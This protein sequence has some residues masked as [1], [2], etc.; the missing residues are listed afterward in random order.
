[1]KRLAFVAVAVLAAVTAAPSFAAT[2]WTVDPVPQPSGVDFTG[3]DGAFV[4]SPTQAWAVGI[5]RQSSSLDFTQLLDS[6]NGR[7]W[8][9]ATPA[10]VPGASITELNAV[11]GSGPDD[12][13]AV[14]DQNGE[15]NSTL[16]EHFDGSS[17]SNFPSPRIADGDLAAVSADGP[18]DAWAVGSKFV[19]QGSN[20]FTTTLT[21]HWNGTAWQVVSNPFGSKSSATRDSLVSVVAISPSDAWAIGV[22]FAGYHSR[23][24]VLEN[25]NGRSWSIVSQPVAGAV[26][27]GLAATG[28][29]DVW[30]V[31]DGGVIEHFNG[32]SWI[33]LPNPAGGDESLSSVAALSPTD[34][35]TMSSDGTLTEQWKGTKWSAVPTATTL[36]SGFRLGALAGLSGGPM[37]AAGGNDDGG[38]N[39]S[40][41]LQQPQP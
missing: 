41:I 24:S 36:P 9:T 33:Q 26:L 14:G 7:S 21:E 40:S 38:N 30:A 27:N 12:V 18:A 19:V 32:T 23:S 25:W 28:P 6:W 3:F 35:W 16:V 39:L 22:T 2:T 5:Q 31:G 13:W 17:W 8:K 10:S 34:A 29:D 15:S 11:S 37:F 20:S 1:V 4:A